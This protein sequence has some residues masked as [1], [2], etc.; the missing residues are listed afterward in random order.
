MG[1]DT[2]VGG[3]E[4][5]VL[6]LTSG[7]YNE[8]SWPRKKEC[9]GQHNW[10]RKLEERKEEMVLLE[11]CTAGWGGWGHSCV[12]EIVSQIVS[13]ITL[14]PSPIVFHGTQ[15]VQCRRACTRRYDLPSCV[16]GTYR[17]QL[18]RASQ[19]AKTYMRGDV[20]IVS[21]EPEER[22]TWWKGSKGALPQNRIHSRRRPACCRRQVG[23]RL[24][25]NGFH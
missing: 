7:D 19:L 11:V 16:L 18:I 8:H 25:T 1:G 10:N 5:G 3:G 9:H 22:E 23:S 4:L 14:F 2:G 21:R 17:T 15:G 6:L 13:S 12:R 20:V 24:T